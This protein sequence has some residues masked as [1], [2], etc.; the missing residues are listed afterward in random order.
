S[1][2]VWDY[3]N[4]VGH[5]DAR[6]Q[7]QDSL[8]AALRDGTLEVPENFKPLR[9]QIAAVLKKLAGRLEVKNADD[10]RQVKTREAVLQS[11]GFKALWDRIKHKTTYRVAF[12]ND[13]L[14]ESCTRALR[15]APP[16][17]RTRLQW[18]R[19]DIAIGRA[20]VE[21]TERRGADTV[22]LSEQDIALPDIL[23]E[24]QDRTQLTRRTIKRVLVE[25]GRLDDFKR[26]PQQFIELAGEAINRCK[27][28]AVVDG[29]KYQRLGG[30]HYYAQQL[31][32]NEELTG[33]LRN[34][35]V[36][37][38]AVYEQVVYDSDTEL[39]FADQLEKND[40]IRMYTKLPGWFTV[41]TPLGS[42][43]PDWALL[44]KVDDGEQLY[45]VVET[46]SGLF[47]DDLRDK[48]RAKIEC[49]KAHFQALAVGES[50]ARYIV[51]RDVNDVLA[52]ISGS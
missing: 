22:V 9:S 10:R 11:A 19:A 28:L 34:L 33:Y 51:V 36:A 41:P 6:G 42:Y 38:K 25:S 40:A 29:I 1:K 3:L 48:E 13:K 7:I 17:D 43:N 26:N 35:M 44:V 30:E 52:A 31:F 49:G 50:P 45:F 14:I 39:T 47:V 4:A 15:D 8:R 21:A 16:I 27:R 18:R 20:G 12:D 24:L 5:I 46:K 23:T 37:E 32:E 2:A